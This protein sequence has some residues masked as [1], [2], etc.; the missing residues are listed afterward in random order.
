MIVGAK[1]LGASVGQLWGAIYLELVW[2]NCGGQ[3][4]WN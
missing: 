4:T 1:L 3:A 2:N